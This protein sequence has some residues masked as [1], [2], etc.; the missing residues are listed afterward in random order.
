ME[1][2][3]EKGLGLSRAQVDGLRAKL[4]TGAAIPAAST[5]APKLSVAKPTLKARRRSAGTSPPS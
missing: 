2:Y 3:F 1:N 5:T 4:L